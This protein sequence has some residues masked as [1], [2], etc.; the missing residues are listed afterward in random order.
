M[1]IRFDS[2]KVLIVGAARGIGSAIALAFADNGATVIAADILTEE[3]RAAVQGG[4]ASHRMSCIEID[5][6]SEESVCAG[7]SRAAEPDGHVDVLVYVA[8]G[9]VGRRPQ[10]IE[11]VP[12]DDFNAVVDVN[13]KGA[14]LSIRAVIPFMKARR[15]GRIVVIASPAGLT[16]SLTGIQSYAAAKHAQV[17]LVKQ[18]AREVGQYG[19]TINAVAPG[20]MATSPDYERQWS[21]YSDEFRNTFADR[22]AVRR[23][24]RPQDIADATLFLASDRASFITGQILPVTGS[25]LL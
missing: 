2:Q 13:L 12:L 19:I 16:T 8:G 22:I 3:L 24:G 5:V 6:T 9:V 1:D 14:F 20:F 18:V 25:P 17:G 23:M 21:S 15:V 10:P 7:I 11:D 4:D